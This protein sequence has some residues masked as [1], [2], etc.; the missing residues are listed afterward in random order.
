MAEPQ[1]LWEVTKFT[2]QSLGFLNALE[3][4]AWDDGTVTISAIADGDA[5]TI[6]LQLIEFREVMAQ[7]QAMIQRA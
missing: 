3:I 4:M 6:E 2:R 7:L 5:T 1:K